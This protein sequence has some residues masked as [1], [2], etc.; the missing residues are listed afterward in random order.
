TSSNHIYETIATAAGI[1]AGPLIPIVAPLLAY[2]IS[3]FILPDQASRE[4]LSIASIL[5]PWAIPAA[6]SYQSE[7]NVVE[8]RA[9][10]L[11][12][13]LAVAVEG[14]LSET[15]RYNAEINELQAQLAFTESH[16]EGFS[17]S[18]DELQG[19]IELAQTSL[20]AIQLLLQEPSITDQISALQQTQIEL[21]TLSRL[22]HQYTE[23]LAS[24]QYSSGLNISAKDLRIIFQRISED[25]KS[26]YIPSYMNRADGEEGVLL[27]CKLGNEHAELLAKQ[28]SAITIANL[29]TIFSNL[30]P[31][32]VRPLD[33]EIDRLAATIDPLPRQQEPALAQDSIATSGM[34]QQDPLLKKA[35]AKRMLFISRT[36]HLAT[37][38]IQAYGY[39]IQS[40]QGA[41]LLAPIGQH[42]DEQAKNP[43]FSL[44]DTVYNVINDI[45]PSVDLEHYV[46]G[47]KV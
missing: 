18:P 43:N 44:I 40:V 16:P 47:I 25:I 14:S 5:A 1:V 23:K 38:A 7:Q 42:L 31:S 22:G 12:N 9:A 21:T 28:Q 32:N 10:T 19:N 41:A 8:Y 2:K 36:T 34:T 35:S 3:S 24:P 29:A 27:L 26:T 39:Y 45:L 6:I 4:V 13:T 11:S 15:T 20:P 17:I 33:S 30:I 46:V 37:M